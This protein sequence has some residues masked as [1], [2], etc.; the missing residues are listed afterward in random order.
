M[1]DD[2]SGVSSGAS[3]SIMSAC[4]LSGAAA[5]V[6]S[7]AV[8]LGTTAGVNSRAWICQNVRT[9]VWLH[10]RGRIL[11]SLNGSK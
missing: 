9:C 3:W 11:L 10:Q 6:A 7:G 2:A 8:S 1:A 4:K 5:V